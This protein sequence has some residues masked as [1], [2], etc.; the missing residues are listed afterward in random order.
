MNAAVPLPQAATPGGNEREPFAS[1][2]I[3]EE[4]TQA[5]NEHNQACQVQRAIADKQW[6]NHDDAIR[7]ISSTRFSTALLDLVK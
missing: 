1:P 2:P 6:A 5:Q 7:R 3:L 4:V